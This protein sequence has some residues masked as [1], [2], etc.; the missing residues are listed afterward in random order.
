MLFLSKYPELRIV[1]KPAYHQIIN[2]I[3]EYTPGKDI[4]FHNR[5]FETDDPEVIEFIKNNNSFGRDIVAAEGI[6]KP[7]VVAQKLQAEEIA[8]RNN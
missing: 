4:Q 6:S 2:G 1:I 5:R 3:R 8:Y 7:S